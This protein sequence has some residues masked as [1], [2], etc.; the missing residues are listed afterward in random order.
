MTG[1]SRRAEQ[2]LAEWQPILR[3][4]DWDI[5]LELVDGGSEWRKRGDVKIDTSNRMAVLMI[6]GSVEER[7]LE[8][9][10]VHELLHIRLYGLD[11]MIEELINC[12]YGSAEEDSKRR[13]AY[14]TFME[15][16]ESTTED[17]TKALMDASGSGG[18]LSF[19]RLEREVEQELGS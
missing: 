1:L 7:H 2:L 19:R 13:F 8:E 6:H 9:L 10:I 18:E 11:Q 3:L 4:A 5:R 16:L 14:S 17:L 15:I 12:F